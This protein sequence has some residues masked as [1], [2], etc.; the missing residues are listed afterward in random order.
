[1]LRDDSAM[2]LSPAMFREFIEP[3]DQRLLDRV[4]GGAVH[5][6]G[7]GDHFIERIGQMRG[8][9]A[10]AMSQPEYNDMEVIFRNTVD[11]GIR[12]LSLQRAAAE[13][14]LKRGRPL[15]GLVHCW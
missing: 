12:L 1:M 14:A 6:C 2:N 10:V 7:R 9:H 8:V 3:Y 4:G 5:F 11:K 15:H 13:A